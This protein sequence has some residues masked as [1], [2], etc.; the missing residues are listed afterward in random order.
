MN[1]T[2]SIRLSRMINE[3]HVQFHES[4]LTLLERVTSQAL[5]VE[6]MHLLYRGAF[7]REQEALMVIRKS[8]K[9]AKILEQD[10]TRDSIFRGFSDTVKGYRNHFDEEYREAANRLWNVLMHYGNIAKKTL[11]AKTAATNDMMREFIKSEN[12]EAME[13]LKVTEWCEKLDEENQKFHQLMMQRYSEPLGKTTY[14]MKTARKETDK[15]YRVMTSQFE[16]QILT[17]GNDEVMNEFMIEL[18][19]IVKRFR[20]IMAQQFGRKNKNDEE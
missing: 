1:S 13:K 9:T 17:G 8:E 15:F 16:Y 11:D 7:D 12:Q 3:I 18:N 10:R 5:R 6:P 20:N 14:R 19:A 2:A 4:V